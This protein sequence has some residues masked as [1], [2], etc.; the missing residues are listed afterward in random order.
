MRAARAVVCVACGVLG[1]LCGD[2]SR[3]VASH[4]ERARE[5]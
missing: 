1:F 5:C 3:I 2:P 4:N